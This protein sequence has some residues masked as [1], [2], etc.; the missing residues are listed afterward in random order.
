[1]GAAP[2][3]LFWITGGQQPVALLPAGDTPSTS[4]RGSTAHR[5]S[6]D[7]MSEPGVRDSMATL[8][9]PVPPPAPER[10]PSRPLMATSF[11]C[12]HPP[13]IDAHL[14]QREDALILAALARSPTD[15]ADLASSPVH[16]FWLRSAAH[17]EREGTS[18]MA[19]LARSTTATSQKKKKK[20]V[21]PKRSWTTRRQKTP[22]RAASVHM[23]NLFLFLTWLAFLSMF[24]ADHLW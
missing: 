12:L 2:D 10:P 15:A 11:P 13:D 18:S 5:L 24:T 1:M 14:W 20:L 22:A 23:V 6:V 4:H 17:S 21:P 3:P 7:P 19:P 16:S 9:N 8:L